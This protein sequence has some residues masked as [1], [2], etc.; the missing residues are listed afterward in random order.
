MDAPRA[1]ADLADVLAT[2][3]VEGTMRNPA[4]GMV[5]PTPPQRDFVHAPAVV[6]R[7]GY[8][9]VAFLHPD[10][11]ALVNKAAGGVARRLNQICRSCASCAP[12]R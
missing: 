1:G 5:A 6:E 7:A 12:S 8:V 9:P 10:V 11:A 3:A 2:G 4:T